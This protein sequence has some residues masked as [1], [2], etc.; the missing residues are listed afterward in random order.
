VAS[1]T[2]DNLAVNDKATSM[3]VIRPLIG[4]DK[5]E[6]IDIAKD[7]GTYEISIIRSKGCGALPNNPA[8]KATLKAIEH[9]E[10]KLDDDL[11]IVNVK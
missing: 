2:L 5:Q 11:F 1:Q 6:I 10:S 4:Y 8:T 7:I 9:E 3:T